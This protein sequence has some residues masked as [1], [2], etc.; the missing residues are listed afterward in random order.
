MLWAVLKS[1]PVA[2]PPGTGTRALPACEGPG[3]TTFSP[4]RAVGGR[5][6]GL[7]G[8]YSAAAAAL[9]CLWPFGFVPRTAPSPRLVADL[10]IVAVREP[11]KWNTSLTSR[12][13]DV[14]CAAALISC[15]IY[16]VAAVVLT[17]PIGPPRVHARNRHE[18]TKSK[19][20]KPFAQSAPPHYLEVNF[21]QEGPAL[22]H[23]SINYSLYTLGCAKRNFRDTPAPNASTP[24]TSW[25]TSLLQPRP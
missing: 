7:C 3:P 23:C 21:H 19:Y 5:L 10:W 9:S 1:G 15:R 12:T 8:T 22:P 25:G 2:W 24:S 18:Q 11:G 13:Y 6:D 14:S 20:S 17:D 4:G 16:T